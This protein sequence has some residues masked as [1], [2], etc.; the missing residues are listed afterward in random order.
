M[1]STRI[2]VADP[3]QANRE[4]LADLLRQLGF[5]ADPVA[6]PAALTERLRSGPVDV[7]ITETSCGLADTCRAVRS[8]NPAAEVAVYTAWTRPVDEVRSAELGCRH[9]VKPDVVNLLGWVADGRGDGPD[10]G[11]CQARASEPA[12]GS[13]RASQRA[14]AGCLLVA[15]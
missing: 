5:A 9:F 11:H 10:G 1:N 6:D 7:V 15:S 14:A 2:I 13:R 4:T 12:I 8:A 3:C